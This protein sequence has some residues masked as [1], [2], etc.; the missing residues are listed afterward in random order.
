MIDIHCHVLHQMDDGA[1]TLTEAV[2]L[3]K[4]ADAND[5]THMVLTPHFYDVSHLDAF[6]ERR[7]DH[8]DQ[9][10]EECE[11]EMLDVQL[12]LGAEVAVSPGLLKCD[13]LPELALNNSRYLLL[14]LPFAEA[15]LS[16]MKRYIERVI[17]VGLVPVLAHPE[18]FMYI[19]SNLE[20]L[21]ELAQYP[22]LFQVNADSLLGAWGGRAIKAATVLLQNGRADVIATDAHSV[23]GRKNDLLEAAD[24]LTRMVPVDVLQKMLVKTPR[25][26]IKNEDILSSQ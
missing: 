7:R 22:L 20:I 6:L 10:C 5:I 3:C 12:L 1:R 23:W 26:I 2:E 13:R 16:E 9:L 25:A 18:R 21:S 11:R 15:R 14:E 17:A 4:I 24:R 8:Y 19:Q